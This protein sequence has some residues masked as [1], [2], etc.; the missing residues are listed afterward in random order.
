[1]KKTIS[2]LLVMM[3]CFVLTMG[4]TQVEAASMSAK[5]GA[6]PSKTE[7]QAGDTITLQL[8]IQNIQNAYQNAV[9]SFSATMEYNTSFFEA[10]TE[11]DCAG[12]SYNAE[13]GML[14]AM[15]TASGDKNIG[16]ITFKVKENPQGK[17]T[18]TFSEVVFAD[19]QTEYTDSNTQCELTLAT[20]QQ[21]DDP[22]PDDPTPDDP[23][24]DDPTPDDPTPDDPTPDKPTPDQPGSQT[25]GTQDGNK[26]PQTT[27]KTDGT[28][29]DKNIPQTGATP[30]F[31]A[32]VAM[33][34]VIGVVAYKKYV[35]Y[36]D[37]R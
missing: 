26:K 19:G 24:P 30:L 12:I 4:G 25:P 29:A 9:T 33:V 31:I 27:D 36:K 2:L 5:L 23:T 20:T 18:I 10:V 37:V 8:K 21:P 35:D 22:T 13:L 17:G 34:G 14:A 1:M 28:V 7:V 3:V 6:I 32:I 15:F 16:T 11:D